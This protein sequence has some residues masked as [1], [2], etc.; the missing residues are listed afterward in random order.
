MPAISIREVRKSYGSLVALDG[1]SLEVEQ[2]EF[3]G[4]L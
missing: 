4:L 2:G 3:F 1:V